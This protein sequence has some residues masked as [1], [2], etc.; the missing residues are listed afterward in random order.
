[1]FPKYSFLPWLEFRITSV[2][3][4]VGLTI[5]LW[6][7]NMAFTEKAKYFLCNSMCSFF[8]SNKLTR[9]LTFSFTA[10]QIQRA[11]SIWTN[12]RP[13]VVRPPGGLW[14]WEEP[15]AFHTQHSARLFLLLQVSILSLTV[16]GIWCLQ[17]STFSVMETLEVADRIPRNSLLDNFISFN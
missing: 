1:M 11:S 16:R 10:R 15:R 8:Q 7:A 3:M 2:N 17:I 4:L 9:V 13:A 6:Q 12:V 5:S 14:E